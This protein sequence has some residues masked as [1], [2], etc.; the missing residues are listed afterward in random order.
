MWA[1][2]ARP[3]RKSTSRAPSPRSG[4]AERW[5]TARLKEYQD[6][7]EVFEPTKK[8]VSTHL[9]EWLTTIEPKRS[10]STVDFYRRMAAHAEPEIGTLPLPRLTA[11]RLQEYLLSIRQTKTPRVQQGIFDTLSAALTKAVRLGLIRENPC[12][13]VERPAHKA[14]ETQALTAEQARDF[15]TAATSE[16]LY[17]L[18]LL[19]VTTALRR[20]ELC[21][22]RWRDVD[23]DASPARLTVRQELIVVE[24]PQ[25]VQGTQEQ[26]QRGHHPDPARR[27]AGAARLAD[28]PGR[29]AADRRSEW[30]DH[31]NGRLVF[32]QPNGKPLHPNNLLKR[33]FRSILARTGLPTTLRIHDLRHT[34]ASVLVGGGA[35]PKTAQALLRPARITTTLGIYTHLMP[36]L[37]EQALGSLGCLIPRND[38]IQG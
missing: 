24:R 28:R 26:D 33:D 1:A 6:T 2:T 16:R 31:E 11:A 4:R 13:R 20:G 37:A 30:Q 17:P 19:A 25:R 12:R 29:G 21:G 3:A 8:T 38:G 27:G 7:D 5:R 15:L 36:G 35:D 23:L 18:W 10:P 9:A 34:V 14:K 32:S 22:L